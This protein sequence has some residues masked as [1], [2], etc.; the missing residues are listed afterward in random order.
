MSSPKTTRSGSGRSR[1][2]ARKE[3][4]PLL[5]ALLRL[6]YHAMAQEL[7]RWLA[8]SGY[9]DLQPSHNAAIQLLWSEP[10]GLRATAL[11]QA[12]HV[13]KQTMSALVDHLERTGYVERVADPA[14]GRAALVRLTAR[15]AKFA[16]D[17]RG[18]A[19]RVESDLAARLGQG[20]V[21][22]L[23]AT[24]RLVHETLRR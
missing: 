24:L 11:A 12:A 19:R 16:E 8:E 6:S 4:G 21:D 13:T 18:F 2:P 10:A 17:V 1:R 22:E 3:E 15:G 9:G 5:G 7:S 14:D 20:R 23:R